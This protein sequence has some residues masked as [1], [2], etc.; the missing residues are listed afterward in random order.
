MHSMMHVCVVE[1]AVR[2]E[3]PLQRAAT[4]QRIRA[5]NSGMAIFNW[6]RRVVRHYFLCEV[7]K[8]RGKVAKKRS[9]MARLVDG[10]GRLPTH[11]PGGQH[12]K[13]GR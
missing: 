1:V 6:I 7:V 2:S 3:I 5:K 8:V 13:S 12:V 10:D 11:T 9:S 4:S